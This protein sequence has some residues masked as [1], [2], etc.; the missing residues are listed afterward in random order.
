LVTFRPEY[1]ASWMQ[2]SYYHQLR[3]APLTSEA[4]AALFR[5]LL[6]ADPALVS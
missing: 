3:L 5:D 2:K 6:G 1:H 4:C